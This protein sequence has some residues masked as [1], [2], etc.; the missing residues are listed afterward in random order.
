MRRGIVCVIFFFSKFINTSFF[1]IFALFLFPC[2]EGCL[3]DNI[4]NIVIVIILC[5]ARPVP[6]GASIKMEGKIGPPGPYYV[7]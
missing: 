5:L 7:I 2:I 1:N 6:L 4:V 3:N